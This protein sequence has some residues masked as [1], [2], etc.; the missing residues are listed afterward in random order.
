[1]TVDS[2]N[3]AP[4]DRYMLEADLMSCW[5]VVDD[6][7]TIRESNLELS[8]HCNALDAAITLANLRFAQTM[9]TFEAYTLSD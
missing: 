1:M 2:H 3:K 8:E 5:Q 9:K 6:L 4:V 7:K